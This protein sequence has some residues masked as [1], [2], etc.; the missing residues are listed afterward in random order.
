MAVVT[1]KS[2]LYRD[3]VTGGAVPDTL[4]VN[5]VMR[6]ATGTLANAA[7]DSSGSKYKLC[8]VPYDAIPHPSTLFDVQAWG[9]A[10]VVIGSLTETDQILDVAKSA[11]AT[12][13]PFAM[14]NALHGLRFWE[15]LGLTEDPGG[16][17]DIYVHA[18]ANATGAGSM[19]FHVAWIHHA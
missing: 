5:G 8:A 6:S 15:V 2:N 9:Y 1:G 4:L 12:Q 18:E 13:S 11:A 19:P 17:F 14:G 16:T 3:P 10:Q 7:G